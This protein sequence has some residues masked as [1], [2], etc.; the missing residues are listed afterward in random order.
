MI[1][2]LDLQAA[3][4]RSE[5]DLAEEEIGLLEQSASTRHHPFSYHD[6]YRLCV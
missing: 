6:A 1:D 3:L 4:E 2:I 5:A